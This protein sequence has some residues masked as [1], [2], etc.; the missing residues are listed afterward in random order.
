V[1]IKV[2]FR[3]SHDKEPTH[4]YRHWDNTK[5]WP[6]VLR[7]SRSRLCISKSNVPSVA[8]QLSQRRAVVQVTGRLFRQWHAAADQTMQQSGAAASNQQKYPWACGG[9][10]TPWRHRLYSTSRLGLEAICLGL[11]LIDL[12][13]GLWPL[14]LVET[15]CAG[16]RRAYLVYCSCS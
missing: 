8:R 15:F 16:A 9:H 7:C 10:A 5:V 14:R 12:V 6:G 3:A 4:I 1:G 13:S 2:F 11:G